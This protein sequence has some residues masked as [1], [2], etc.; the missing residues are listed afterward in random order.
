MVTHIGTKM[1]LWGVIAMQAPLV[2]QQ[3][4][5]KLVHEM[6]VTGGAKLGSWKHNSDGTHML[7]SIKQLKDSHRFCRNSVLGS[8]LRQGAGQVHSKGMTC[9][10]ELQH[11]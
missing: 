1:G 10:P 9:I 11:V 4:G 3:D 8:T 2:A 5:K 7:T 6:F